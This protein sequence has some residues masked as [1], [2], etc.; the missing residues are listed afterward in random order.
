M[1]AKEKFIAFVDILAFK[2]KVEEAEKNGG[3]FSHLVEL[4]AELGSA[5][6]V[7]RLRAAPF[8]CPQSAR[9]N[10]DLD[11]CATQISDCVVISTE[12]S[13]AGAITL[14]N[15][16][17]A[18][19][20]KMLRKN[21][22]CRGY[23]TKGNIFHTESQFFG[24]GYQKAYSSERYVSFRSKGQHD[25]GTPFIQID[26]LVADYVSG[27]QDNCVQTMFGRAT[28]TD[29]TYWAIYPF[30]ALGKTSALIQPGFEPLKWKVRVEANLINYEARVKDFEELKGKAPDDRAR[31]K[32]AYYVAGIGEVVQ[33]LEEKKARLEDMIASENIPYGSVL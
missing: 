28:R 15:H 11:I 24:T 8:I 12:V 30:D 25:E 6:E 14:I 26:Q 29:G 22:L 2:N 10:P 20:S 17:C 3:D 21:A 13:P 18:L 23:V 16:C 9:V 1:Q 33:R 27:C 5:A 4:T 19:A 32:I 7:E 31:A